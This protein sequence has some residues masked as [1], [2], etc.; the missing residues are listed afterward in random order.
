MDKVK[1]NM[2]EKCKKCF[3]FRSVAKKN[4]KNPFFTF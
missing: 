2:H 3:I 1:R 4:T